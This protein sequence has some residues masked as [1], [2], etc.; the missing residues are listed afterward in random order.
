MLAGAFYARAKAKGF[1]EV[2]NALMHE[3][4]L[5]ATHSG[6]HASRVFRRYALWAGL[7]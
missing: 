5:S 1:T 3:S 7:L 6:N 2:I 4:N